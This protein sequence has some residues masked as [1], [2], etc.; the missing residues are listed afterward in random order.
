MLLAAACV[1]AMVAGCGASGDSARNAEGGSNPEVAEELPVVEIPARWASAN[2]QDMKTLI[3]SSGTVFVG[4][5]TGLS[6]QRTVELGGPAGDGGPSTA[7]NSVKS[8]AV[9]RQAS[10]PISVFQVTVVRS[11]AGGLAAGETAALEQPGGV[12]TRSDGSRARVAFEGDEPLT[13]GTRYLIFAS[14]RGDGVL[15]S[16]PFGRFTVRDGGSIAP[17][18][19]WSGL[20]VARQLTG[21]NVDEAAG[22]VQNAR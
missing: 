8:A 20:P 14:V 17:L 7:S 22:E 9:R 4:E 13:I 2:A 18:E 5:V 11:L 3:T 10:I 16:A 21:V 6:E 15:T 19:G 12:I 1:V